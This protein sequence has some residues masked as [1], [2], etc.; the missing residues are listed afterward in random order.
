[1]TVTTTAG[2]GSMC[3][4]PAEHAMWDADNDTTIRRRADRLPDDTG[5]GVC[6]YC[7]RPLPAAV[8]S[9]RAAA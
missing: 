6:G 7:G 2:V 1:M 4:A 5:P 8:E 9:T 3:P